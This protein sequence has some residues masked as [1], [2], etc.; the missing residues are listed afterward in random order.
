MRTR[1]LALAGLLAG[2]LVLTACGDSDD[3]TVTG[4]D[5]GGGSSAAATDVSDADVTFVSGMVP[6]HE[7]AV[8][9]SQVIL[10]KDPS[11][12]VR[13]LAERVQAAQTP[14]IDQLN[15]MLEAFGEHGGDD[16]H[17]GSGGAHGGA[18][19][20]G[21]AG[22]MTEE[23]MQQ[24]RGA[25]GVDAERLWLQ[26]M[27]EHHRGAVEMS[28]VQIADGTY[29]PAIEL[30]TKIRD[31]QRAEIAEMEQLLTRL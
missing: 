11:P 31:D 30:A 19:G 2:T 27:L 25:T 1:A 15:G 16:P 3:P 9:M 26:M 24:L 22:M 17:G 6:H 21:H 8:E 12:P 18:D 10:D 5:A 13:A 29:E 28:E 23:Q 20:A 7:Q 14:E 4:Q